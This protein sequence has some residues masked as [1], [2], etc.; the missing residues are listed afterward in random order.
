MAQRLALYLEERKDRVVLIEQ[1]FA[2]EVGRA[3]LSGKAD[4]IE[5]RPEGAYVVDLKTGKSVP[6]AADAADNGQLAM[7][8]LAVAS[9]GV[10][11]VSTPA[12][13]ELAYVSTGKAGATRTQDPIDPIAARERLDAVVETMTSAHFPAVVNDA[14][15]T[16]ALRKACP[17]HAEGDQV[18]GR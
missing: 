9:G 4:R 1:P 8:Q 14:C 6:S 11:G 2:V 17:A 5:L 16:C 7:Y 3:V 10:E 15:G 12:G 13:A 18:T